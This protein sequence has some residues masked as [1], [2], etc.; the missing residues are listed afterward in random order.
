MNEAEFRLYLR[1]RSPITEI[2]Q[3]LK[4]SNSLTRPTNSIFVFSI[5]GR[6]LYIIEIASK[7]DKLNY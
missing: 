5:N 7:C 3:R 1:F 6:T 4:Q 2:L